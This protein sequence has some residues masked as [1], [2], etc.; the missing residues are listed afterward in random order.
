[1]DDVENDN[2]TF[3]GEDGNLYKSIDGDIYQVIACEPIPYDKCNL[4]FNIKLK[5]VPTVKHTFEFKIKY[6]E[7]EK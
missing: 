3:K 2:Y 4:G 1:M 7:N 6:K 5:K